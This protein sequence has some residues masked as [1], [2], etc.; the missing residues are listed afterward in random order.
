MKLS[1]E[2]LLALIVLNQKLASR[3]QV[4][5]LLKRKREQ[6]RERGVNPPLGQLLTREKIVSP[7]EFLQL[8]EIVKQCR[9]RCQGCQREFDVL[10]A[11][12]AGRRQCLRCRQYT[13]TPVMAQVIRKST[14]QRQGSARA[15]AR[16]S[17]QPGL[18][19]PDDHG[20]VL[21]EKIG[22]YHITGYIATGGMGVI[23]KAR[24]KGTGPVVALKVLRAGVQGDLVERFKREGEAEARLKHPNIVEVF[25]LGE[26]ENELFFTM[27][28]VDGLPFDEYLQKKPELSDVI[29]LLV[30]IA[31]G[32]DYAHDNGL[33][34]RDMK[35]Q[36]V[37]ITK[38][39]HAKIT[40][41]GLARDLGQ[42]SLSQ[43]GDLIGTPLYMAPE[44]LDRR[45]GKIDRRTDVF[46]L[47]VILFQ[48]LTERLPFP[49]RSLPE[50]QRLLLKEPAPPPSLIQPNIP[51][52]LEGICLKA[53]EKPPVNR[54]QTARD[55]G[56]DLEKW[57]KGEKLPAFAPSGSGVQFLDD[58][59]DAAQPA[60]LVLGVIVMVFFVVLLFTVLLL[61]RDTGGPTRTPAQRREAYEKRQKTLKERIDSAFR[62][63]R[64]LMSAARK[65]E[66]TNPKSSQNSYLEALQHSQIIQESLSKYESADRDLPRRAQQL[67]QRVRLKLAAIL[68][69][70]KPVPNELVEKC[71]KPLEAW[72]PRSAEVRLAFAQADLAAGRAQLALQGFHQLYQEYLTAKLR[73]QAQAPSRALSLQAL[74]GR[75]QAHHLAKRYKQSISDLK[76]LKDDIQTGKAVKELPEWRVE[77]ALG[78]AYLGAGRRRLARTFLAFARKR[79]RDK[80][81]AE[82]L[83]L[84]LLLARLEM[85]SGRLRSADELLTEAEEL[86]P[87]SMPLLE[88]RGELYTRQKLT[89]KALRSLVKAIDASPNPSPK[90]FRL[91]ALCTIRKALGNEQADINLQKALRDLNRLVESNRSDATARIMRA[92]LYFFL[93][94]SNKVQRELEDLAKA[95]K[96][97]NQ[98]QRQWALL[99]RMHLERA[100]GQRD[101]VR[102]DIEAQ[103]R[104]LKLESADTL[105]TQ[106]LNVEATELDLQAGKKPTR[107]F[108]AEF[109]EL[110]R[111]T[112]SVR[113]Y[114]LCG[115]LAFVLEDSYRAASS[116]DEALKRR[117][118]E[119]LSM[120]LALAARKAHG[121]GAPELEEFR[122]KQEQRRQHELFHP[123]FLGLFP[124]SWDPVF[125]ALFFIR[126]AKFLK[127]QGRMGEA[128]TLERWARNL[129]GD[130]RFSKLRSS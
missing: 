63:C 10:P 26:G 33:I 60:A 118:A 68:L 66:L 71:L 97:L 81:W 77:L 127:R 11:K 73:R 55:F 128:R 61:F 80:A 45:V 3:T 25:D 19:K 105:L 49:A 125:E 91:R 129:L 72:R 83:S 122:A 6:F 30:E 94:L 108:F 5:E 104:A 31:H 113:M 121:V 70:Q 86:N 47:G 93:G 32:L 85:D 103:L 54:H 23:Y 109:S 87:Q 67:E 111:S 52:E 53:L 78:K 62:Q 114:R 28:L 84:L 21:P 89:D 124:D 12:R 130:D 88:L 100:L 64:D 51:P 22:P 58:E 98:Q 69:K 95:C 27:E 9:R 42:S 1:A 18:G 56:L 120:A 117:P 112:G 24:N 119:K 8:R 35:P 74:F 37:L 48:I 101:K 41:F 106:C 82:R 96:S 123:D 99:T 102:R 76:L 17:A 7:Q 116:F 38:D 34:H 126:R 14:R 92:R 39:G 36:N 65:T 115:E 46:A 90:V 20:K 43:D 2:A 75:A 15:A 79:S 44:Q 29:R 59:D 50:L 13:P 110:A 4:K 40:D 16:A 57:L 107:V